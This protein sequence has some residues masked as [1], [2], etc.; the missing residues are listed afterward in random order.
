M[1][2]F[3]LSFISFQLSNIAFRKS[4]V[5]LVYS[6]F[7]IGKTIQRHGHLWH[8]SIPSNPK[9]C[10]ECNRLLIP[11]HDSKKE[12]RVITNRNM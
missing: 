3:P 12:R 1:L 5:Q 10:H 9:S 7:I 4:Q 6:I 8:E 11:A 2:F